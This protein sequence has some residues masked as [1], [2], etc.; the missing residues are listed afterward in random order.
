MILGFIAEEER[1]G[2]DTRAR[3]GYGFAWKHCGEDGI[4]AMLRLI[5][6]QE[7]QWAV[8]NMIM[9]CSECPDVDRVLRTL[10]AEQRSVWRSAQGWCEKPR[11]CDI[12]ADWLCGYTDGRLRFPKMGSVLER[13]EAVERVRLVLVRDRNTFSNLRPR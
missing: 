3:G 10:L 8:L 7:R 11:V 4:N 12:T 1:A 6:V 2:P 13:D 5:G 9:C